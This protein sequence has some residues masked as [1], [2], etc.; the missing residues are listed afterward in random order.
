MA[1]ALCIN[2]GHGSVWLMKAKKVVT[3]FGVYVEGE[4]WDTTQVGSPYVPDDY[5][6][7]YELVNLPE[8]CILRWVEDVE[9]QPSTRQGDDDGM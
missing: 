9:S 6:G 8:S 5:A 2:P 4:A 1:S 7:E 3:P